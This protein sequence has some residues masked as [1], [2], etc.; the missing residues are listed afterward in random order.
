MPAALVFGD[1][2]RQVQTE[3][4][5]QDGLCLRAARPIAPGSRCTVTFDLPLDGGPR[6]VTAAL[7]TV[8]SSY[9]AAGEFKVG[10]RFVA[11]D[12]DLAEVLARFAADA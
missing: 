12:D 4:V 8:Y 3:D 9:A 11:L 1:E 7:R 5:G 6:T 2:T 10:A